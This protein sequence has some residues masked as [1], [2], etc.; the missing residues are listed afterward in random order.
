MVTRSEQKQASLARILDVTARRLREEGIDGAAI[1]RV[2]K[3][4][5]LT[6]GAF[7]AHFRNKDEL[8]R[9]GFMHAIDTGQPPWFE[10]GRKPKESFRDRLKRMAA[11][12]LNPRH[13]DRI[14]E[15]CAISALATDVPK[16]SPA[17]K[18]TYQRVLKNTF[19]KIADDDPAREDDAIQF[20]AICL[21]GLLLARNVQDAELS[22]RILRVTREQAEQVAD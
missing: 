12:Y 22:D 13:R 3:E 8:T 2:M 4:A 14:E 7:Y 5:E 19:K 21:G 1:S 9:A 6:H 11:T 18:A 20:M 15:G 10:N 16:S 17:F